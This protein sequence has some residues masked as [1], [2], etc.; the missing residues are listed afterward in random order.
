M[1]LERDDG[2]SQRV[3]GGRGDRGKQTDLGST[4]E[5]H[6]IQFINEVMYEGKKWEEK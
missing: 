1:V 5:V 6:L 4:V 2:G 3:T